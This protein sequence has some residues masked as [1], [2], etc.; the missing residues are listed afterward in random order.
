MVITLSYLII[1]LNIVLA[2][3]EIPVYIRRIKRTD[4][5]YSKWEFWLFE[6][7][8][9]FFSILLFW[10]LQFEKQYSDI[11][12]LATVIG[13]IGLITWLKYAIQFDESGFW[14]F[15]ILGQKKRYEYQDVL[16]IK[17]KKRE[18]SKPYHRTER[19]AV[20]HLPKKKVSVNREYENYF[21]FME[22]MAKKYKEVHGHK[23]VNK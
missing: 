9:I 21:E 10:I 2:I 14:I 4:L 13:C 17:R 3:I 19:I 23:M 6:C 1:V 7:F 22:K 5:V 20:I 8:A 15:N 16:M 11:G 12:L 18:Y